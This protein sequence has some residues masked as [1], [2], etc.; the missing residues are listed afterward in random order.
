[1]LTLGTL[2]QILD[3]HPDTMPVHVTA[4]LGHDEGWVHEIVNWEVAD[5]HLE[6]QV[7]LERRYKHTVDW[8]R[9]D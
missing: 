6:L 7:V 5:G 9:G 3:D 1:M 8:L 4:F 2:R